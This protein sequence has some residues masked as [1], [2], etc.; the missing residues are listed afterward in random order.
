MTAFNETTRRDQKEDLAAL[1]MHLLAIRALCEKQ[2]SGD[3]LARDVGTITH[4]AIARL[5]KVMAS[6]GDST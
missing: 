3:A 4:G 1:M 2:S 5:S 6:L